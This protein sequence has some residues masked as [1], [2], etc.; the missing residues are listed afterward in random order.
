MASVAAIEEERIRI[1]SS[2]LLFYNLVIAQQTLHAACLV[3]SP[4]AAPQTM[5]RLFHPPPGFA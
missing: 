5:A 4:P 3:A 2:T 1:S